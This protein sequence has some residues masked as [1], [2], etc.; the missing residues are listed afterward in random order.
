MTGEE[1]DSQLTD[2]H[3]PMCKTGPLRALCCAARFSL[4]TQKLRFCLLGGKV[5]GE[6]MEVWVGH[7]PLSLI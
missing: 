2:G 7:F 3:M 4:R 5:G 6:A 1:P